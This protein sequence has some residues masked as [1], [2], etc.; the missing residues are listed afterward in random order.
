M[1]SSRQ[2]IKRVRLA[3]ER[4]QTDKNINR[5]DSKLLKIIRERWRRKIVIIKTWKSHTA[6]ET[7][8]VRDYG[9]PCHRRKAAR[10]CDEERWALV[11]CTSKRAQKHIRRWGEVLCFELE[12]QRWWLNWEIEEI[13]I[14]KSVTRVI[15]V[16]VESKDHSINYRVLLPL[17][18][19]ACRTRQQ[20][21]TREM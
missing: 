18:F 19:Q 15:I 1:K 2:A 8:A 4:K 9:L 14:L 10:R 16:I 5:N 21:N 17:L 6:V 20:D 7:R 3:G 12:A 13:T 11:E